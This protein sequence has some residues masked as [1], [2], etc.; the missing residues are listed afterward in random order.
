MLLIFIFTV[1]QAAVQTSL[2]KYFNKILKNG[3]AEGDVNYVWHVGLYM[4]ILTVALGFCMMIA[5][6]FSAFVTARFTTEIRADLFRKTQKFSDLDYVKFSKETLLTRANSDTTQMQVVVINM[7]RNAMLVPFVAIFTFIRCIM[8][9]AP[10]SLV[11][12]FALVLSAFIVKRGNS[13]SMPL[14]HQLQTKTDRVSTLMNEKLTGARSIRAFSRQD[15]EIDKLTKANEEVRDTAIEANNCIV[16]LM[17]LVQVIMDLV[18]VVVLLLGPFQLKN[19]AVEL[20]D[21]M[22]FIQYSSTLAAGFATIM[23]IVNA[24]PKCEVAAS[25]IKEVLDYEVKEI[26]DKTEEIKNPKGEI[27]FNNVNFGYSGADDY[28]LHDINLTIPA[29][30]TTAIVGATGSGKSTLLKLIPLFFDTNFEG[31]IKVDGVDTKNVKPYDLRKLISYAPQKANLYSGTVESNL[32]VA[33]PDATDEEIRKACDM[34]CV[35]EFLK[36][37]GADA[38]FQLT[39]GGSNLSGGQRQRVSVARAFIRDAYIYLLD[40]TFSA[41]D[42]KTDAAVRKAMYKE[43]AGKTIVVV[44]QRVATIMNADKIVVMD[45]GCI[46]AEGTHQ[47]LLESCEIYQE[48]YETQTGLEDKE[49]VAS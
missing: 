4:L 13:R 3:V 39:Q 38:K 14:F 17:P 25:R 33:K 24:L 31:S 29:G 26:S 9:D 44:A 27:C 5:G 37:K 8:L 47:E 7:L 18:I 20:A 16:H 1:A 48:I 11:L 32:K 21:L 41:L 49:G 30:K 19:G 42:F 46:V 23:A 22:T 12:V 2:P 43:L 36:A 45:K 6:Y 28:V 10:L 40:D 15:Y 35:T 34:A